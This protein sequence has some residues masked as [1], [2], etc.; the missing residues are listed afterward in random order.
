MKFLNQLVTEPV[1]EYMVFGKEGEHW[2]KNADGTR[3]K[4]PLYEEES[5]R[6]H[7][8]DGLLYNSKIMQES[9]GSP[10]NAAWYW[11]VQ[12]F[13]GDYSKLSVYYR[14]PPLSDNVALLYNELDTYVRVELTKFM[15]GERPLEEYD[16]FIQELYDKY[17]LQTIC[18]ELTKG[19]NQ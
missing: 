3:K 18:D 4:L 9:D 10:E 6:W 11:P 12:D 5:Y 19:Y 8:C 16:G 13:A 14:V 1:N 7:Y 17:E 2:E 15:M